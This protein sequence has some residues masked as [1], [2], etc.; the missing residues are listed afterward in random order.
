MQALNFWFDKFN[1]FCKKG[2]KKKNNI[3]SP[4]SFLIIITPQ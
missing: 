3:I 1:K 2:R 4:F